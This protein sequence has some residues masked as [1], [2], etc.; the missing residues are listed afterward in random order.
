VNISTLTKIDKPWIYRL[1]CQ[2]Y[3]MFKKILNFKNIDFFVLNGSFMKTSDAFYDELVNKIK[4]PEYFG[5]NMNAL[6]ECLTDSDIMQGDI[7]II[8]IKNG[9]DLLVSEPNDFLESFIDTLSLV[10]DEWA[11]PVI[12]KEI[13]D[14]PAKS[15]HTVICTKRGNVV[16]DKLPVFK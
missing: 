6:S 4:L 15:F 9:D 7:F 10:A 16:L 2:D 1:N 12:D 8:F 13:W 14:R 11:T 3:I 5:R